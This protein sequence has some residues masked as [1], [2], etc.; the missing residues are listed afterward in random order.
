VVQESA[1]INSE[2]SPVPAE[3]PVETTASVSVGMTGIAVDIQETDTVFTVVW[4][5]LTILIIYAGIKG[6]NF[7]FNKLSNK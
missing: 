7:L 2:T 6:I 1:V 3:T 5:I 4:A